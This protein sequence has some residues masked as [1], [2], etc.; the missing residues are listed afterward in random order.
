MGHYQRWN[1]E[2]VQLIRDNPHLTEWELA[3]KLGRT[4]KA[5]HHQRVRME[6]VKHRAKS[7]RAKSDPADFD[8]RPSGW[9]DETIG[10]LLIQ[11]SDAFETWK[12]YHRY[13]EVIYDGEAREKLGSWVTL[14]CRRDADAE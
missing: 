1:D 12:H 3:D 8:T 2:D 6:L 14:Q 13:V 11:C 5:V 10:S 4:R 9:Y 7:T